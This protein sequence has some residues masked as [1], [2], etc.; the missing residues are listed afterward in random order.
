[1]KENRNPIPYEPPRVEAEE[2]NIENG[3]RVSAVFDAENWTEVEGGDL[4]TE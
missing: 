3:Y 4:Y 2:V 1:M